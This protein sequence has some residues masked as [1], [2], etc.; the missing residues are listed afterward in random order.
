MN[1]IV[2]GATG[3][4]GRA[5]MAALAARGHAVT[6]FAR[7]PSTLTASAALRI[8]QG[9]VMRADEVAAAMPGHDAAIVSLGNAQN[10]FARLLGARRTTPADVC[11]VGTRHIV[12]A[13]IQAE[14][15][16]LIVVSAFGIG[17]Q[18]NLPLAFRLFYRTVLREQMADKETQEALVKNSGLD[19]T[20][21]QPVG[22]T[23]APATG[24]WFADRHGT[25]RKQQ[26]PRADV[27]A[28]LA[29]LIEGPDDRR[30]T[31]ALSG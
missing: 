8:V 13:M 10:P 14:I 4:T 26:I 5:T 7:N 31:I 11:A 25:M 28:F 18:D 1:V 24:S 17:N 23:D 29:T 16:R 3:G 6:A 27:A 21:V 9:D 15:S 19:W 12:A 30:Q 2:F 22:L 20:I